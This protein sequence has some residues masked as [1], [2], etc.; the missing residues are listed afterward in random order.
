MVLPVLIIWLSLLADRVAGDPPNRY[1]PVAWLGRFIG[2]WGRPAVYPEKIRRFAGFFMGILTAVLFSL[3]FFILDFYLP[4]WAAIVAAPF[5]LKICL[6]WRCLEEHVANVEKALSLDGDGRS[7]VGMLVS[8]DPDS[9][10][11]EEVLSAA[12][13]SMS[14]NLTDSIVS[15]LFY[16]SLLGLGGAAFFRAS[17]TMDA[18]L[19]Y[20]DERIKIGWFPAR[21]DDLLN[22]IPAR[23]A[24]LSLVIW[25]AVKGSLGDARA[26]LKRDRKKR[27]GP[28]GGVTMSL[29]AGGCGIAFIKPGVYVIGDKKRSL[30]EAGADIRDAVR[31]ATIISA[32]ILSLVLLAAGGIVFRFLLCL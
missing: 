24:G 15:P 17:N 21:L 23:L 16:Y 7:E 22:F 30:K 13:E 3:P 20:R 28:N 9:L 29:I 25:F 10:S 2:W 14:E 1:H 12:Y 31:A 27:A 32:V 6:A 8:R 5:L 11:E 18:M 4:V 19:G 26:V